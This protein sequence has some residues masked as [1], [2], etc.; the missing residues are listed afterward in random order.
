MTPDAAFLREYKDLIHKELDLIQDVIKRMAANSFQVKAWMAGIISFIAAFERGKLFSEPLLLLVLLVPIASFW[1]LDG[2]FLQA[3]RKYRSLYNEVIRKR[4]AGDLS[5]LYDL[6]PHRFNSATPS[7]WKIMQT[8][9]LWPFYLI[10][11]VLLLA[12]LLY[13]TLTAAPAV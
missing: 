4:T 7:I 3:E 8:K 10:P 5:G 12:A 6:N 1:Y 2:F 9:T 13:M 11:I